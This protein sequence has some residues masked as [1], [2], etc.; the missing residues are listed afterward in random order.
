[1]KWNEAQIFNE[2]ISHAV[3]LDSNL[4]ARDAPLALIHARFP[5]IWNRCLERVPELRSPSFGSYTPMP[6]LYLQVKG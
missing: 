4:P 6:P 5:R 3:Y 2:A 1:M